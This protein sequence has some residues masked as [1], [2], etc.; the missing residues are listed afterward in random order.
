MFQSINFILVLY[1]RI[2]SLMFQ[3]KGFCCHL[4][5]EFRLPLPPVPLVLPPPP[6]SSS[7]EEVIAE[8]I[9][10]NL[11]QHRWKDLDCLFPA[12]TDNL[13]CHIFIRFRQ[14][15]QLVLYFFQWS[16][17]KKRKKKLL[18]FCL[19]THCVL[20]HVLMV[21]KMFIETLN[22]MKW[23][24]IHGGVAALDLLAAL[25]HLYDDTW[26][27]LAVYDAVVRACTQLRAKDDAYLVIKTLR[28][29]GIMVSIHAW[30]NY[31]NC[32][33]MLRREDGDFWKMYKE[34]LMLGYVANVN[35]FNLAILALCRE[36][37]L[38][39]A[40]SMFSQMVKVGIEPN[41]V[42]IN[43]LVDGCCQKND[44]SLAFDFI[45]NSTLILGHKIEPNCVTCNCLINGFCKS[46]RSA[47][48][49][50]VLREYMNEWGVEPNVRTYATLVDGFARKE[51]LMRH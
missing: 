20:I 6:P 28:N 33:L 1:K 21:A 11:R 43:M 44:I 34:M 9:I 36:F 29:K 48:G 8:A 37:R 30:N 26:C 12:I 35:T 10:I 17:W 32:V 22:I 50:R 49:E 18:P 15:P 46:G 16:N 42:T 14:S 25:G 5:S 2:P 45:K 24:M 31:L 19:D 40:F 3:R 38:F 4:Q 27:N 51:R 47:L 39:E 41:I 23:L 13:A 7:F